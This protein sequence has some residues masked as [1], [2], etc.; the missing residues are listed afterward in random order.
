MVDLKI[1]ESYGSTRAR[2]R[3]VLTATTI[4]ESPVRGESK[5]EKTDRIARNRKRE[6]DYKHK[7]K[8]VSLVQARVVSGID[9]SLRHHRP[10]AAI[11]LAWDSIVLSK[12][13]MPLLLYAQNKIDVQRA[14]A[15]LSQLPNGNDYI[16]KEKDKPVGVNM[17][18]FIEAEVN[19]IR[20]MVNRRW[21]A[22]KN[23]YSNLWPYFAYEAR[24][25]GLVGKC[26]A[27]VMSQRADMMADQFGIRVHDEQ[28][29]L[30]GLLY[31]H[32]VDFVRS[33]WEV[34]KQMRDNNGVRETYITKEGI[35]W[36]NPH[37][38]R[39]FWDLSHPLVTLN[40]DSGCEYVGFW[41][42]VRYGEIENNNNY[43][44]RTEIGF[45]ENMWG[46]A[47]FYRQFIDYFNQYNFVVKPPGVDGTS[48][49]GGRSIDIAGQNDAK[50]FIGLY[51]STQRDS[52]MFL[53]NYFHKLVPSEWGLGDYP[54]QVW[55]RFVF[56]S[57][58]V[59]IYAEFLPSRPCAVLSINENQSRAVSVSM[60]MDLMQWQQHMTNLLTHL[61]NLLQIEGFKAI[62][63]NK[64]AL[65]ASE[66]A[67]IK[68]ILRAKDWY[69][70]PLVYEFSLAQKLEQLQQAAGKALTEIITISEAKQGQSIN[71]IFDAMTKLVALAE[72]M[73][74]MSAAESGQSEP[75]EISATQTNVIANTTQTIYSSISD[76]IDNFR[77]AKKQIIYESTV[78]CS[79]GKINCPVKN[80]YTVETIKKAGFEPVANED[81]D[82]EFD[83][84]RRTVIGSAKS[85]V[86]EFIFS[87]RD[88]SERPVNTQ[89]ANTLTQLIGYTLQV[90]EIAK[91]M[92]REK[93]YSIFN[94][95]FRLSGSGFDLNLELMEGEG[96]SLGEDEM[97][98]LKQVVEQMT[99][100][101]QQLGQQTKKN[102]ADIAE[103][104][105]INQQQQ[106]HIDLAG[107]LAK[108]VASIASQVQSIMAERER[109]IEP[110]KIPYERAPWSVQAQMERMNG[111]TPAS[112]SERKKL[113]AE[114]KPKVSAISGT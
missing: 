27:D 113:L 6:A 114:V 11:D 19:I 68:K 99:Q 89:A 59:P 44:N 18:K 3:E 97:A 66:V 13:N 16:I 23:K 58:S 102:A 63:I 28:V 77:E 86:H 67:A 36:I 49:D 34:E 105:G 2:L 80:R 45:G 40:S 98:N 82:I 65:E 60:A 100:M 107:E 95:V 106:E 70:D 50:G 22:Q 31:A 109:K 91:A 85:L 112:D 30:D 64:D 108:Q 41:D 14:V 32:S 46:G 21:A 84:K 39:T 90:P 74:A 7:Q 88:G 81:E 20:S 69:A 47:G 26:R 15:S 52:A 4:N 56:A 10:Y 83:A 57:D 37:P 29:M 71:T 92:G 87:S 25:T 61:M 48:T 110:P 93:I 53:T 72:R 8:L 54:F 94:E 101:F 103:Q 62:G 12:I 17:P 76:A 73:Q 78:I 55:T 43:F 38:T 96:N 79:E 1:L 51:N 42:V 35:G 33:A 75:R 9:F 5:K 24:S 111:L 104:A